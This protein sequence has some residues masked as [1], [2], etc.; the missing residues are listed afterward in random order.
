MLASFL[1]YSSIRCDT[2]RFLASI[3]YRPIPSGIEH[4]SLGACF[5]LYQSAIG[6]QA[7]D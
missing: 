7:S 1:S 3:P 2:V 6:K 4:A 5:F